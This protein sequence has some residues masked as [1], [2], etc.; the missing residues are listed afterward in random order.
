MHEQ[1]K[2]RTVQEVSRFVA[3]GA[4]NGFERQ[5]AQI[6]VAI[7]LPQILARV[8]ERLKKTESLACVTKCETNL[9][10]SR[11]VRKVEV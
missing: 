6:F 4:R 1:P 10:F 2:P 9:E 3:H 11:V 8:L 7:N 5:A